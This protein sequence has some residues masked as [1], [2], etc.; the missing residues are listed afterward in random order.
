[1]AAYQET[2][3]HGTRDF[4]YIV[5]PVHVP[6]RLNGFP[7]HWHDEMEIIYVS[8]GAVS[9][10]L[11]N[12]EY[13]LDKGDI[14][15]V[16]PQTIHAIKQYRDHSARYYNILFRFSMLESGSKDICREKYFQPIYDRELLMPE[17]LTAEHPLHG[18]LKPLIQQLLVDP[19]RQRTH[20]ELMIKELMIKSRVFEIM[21][22]ILPYCEKADKDSAYED[23]VFEKLKRSLRYLEEHFA[24]DLTIGHMA[25]ISNYSASHFSKLFRQLTGDSFTQYLKR[26]RLETA[27]ERIRTEK[28]KISEIAMECGFSNLSYFSRTFNERYKMSPSEYRKSTELTALAPSAYPHG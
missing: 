18:E 4:P 15:L 22:R 23:I 14:V 24:D 10:S 12:E 26:F 28:A 7:H 25:A 21:Y 1:M 17:R 5:Y 19:R 2:K 8:E 6:E 16:H 9:V 11:R 3:I 13:I 27:A 20:D